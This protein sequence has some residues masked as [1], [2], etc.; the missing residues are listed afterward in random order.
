MMKL[1]TIVFVFVFVFGLELTGSV[2][3]CV[4]LCSTGVGCCRKAHLILSLL[5][6]LLNIFAEACSSADLG[7]SVES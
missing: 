6:L 3:C 5:S 2:L 4:Q 1:V 7:W